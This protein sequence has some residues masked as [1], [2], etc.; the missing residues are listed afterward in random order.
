MHDVLEKYKNIPKDDA[1]GI[2]SSVGGFEFTCIVGV[3]LGAAANN[4]LV[5]IDGFNT[6]ACALVAKTFSSTGN[7]LCNG[8]S[9]IC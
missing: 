1:I 9:F 4:A 5:I 7:G 6:S 3:I 2:L 8:I